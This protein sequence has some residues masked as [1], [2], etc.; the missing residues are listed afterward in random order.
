MDSN[1]KTQSL[2]IR[3]AEVLCSWRRTVGSPPWT[4]FELLRA[5]QALIEPMDGH[6]F[7][8]D[9]CEPDGRSPSGHPVR[10]RLELGEGPRNFRMRH[11]AANRE[12][13]PSPRLIATCFAGP[14]FESVLAAQARQRSPT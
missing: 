12:D 10:T 2:A 11:P 8:S 14:R 3:Y 1:L 9:P 6:S 13:S 7:Q 5:K 4:R